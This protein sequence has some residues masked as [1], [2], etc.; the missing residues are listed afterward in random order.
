[1]SNA[2]LS[3]SVTST[4]SI[5]TTFRADD[6]STATPSANILDVLSLDVTDNNDNGIQTRA[7]GNDVFVQFTNRLQGSATSTN[8]SNADVVTFSLSGS[9]AVYRFEFQVTGL[10]TAGAAVGQGV[11]YT[12]FG[13][14]RTDGAT[15]TII[16]TPMQD[17]DEDAALSGSA[18]SLTTSGNNVI[19]R[20]NGIAGETIDFKAVGSYVVI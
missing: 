12:L 1:M 8:A 9:A 6:L 14:A 16:G 13:S 19:L 15:A 3:D 2:D 5:P 17:V 7:S 18:I 4:P 11:G 20:L 10:S